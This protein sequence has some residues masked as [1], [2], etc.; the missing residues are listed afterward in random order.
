[1]QQRLEEYLSQVEHELRTVPAPQRDEELRE[2]RQHL[3]D[4]VT[5]N[6]EILGYDEEQAVATALEEFGAPKKLAREILAAWCRGDEKTNRRKVLAATFCSTASMSV[7]VAIV[8]SLGH[9][10][11]APPI[12]WEHS[13]LMQGNV[14]VWAA[15]TWAI[16][17]AITA[18][19]FA[20]HPKIG[21]WIAL[22]AISVW[23]YLATISNIEQPL[24]EFPAIAAYVMASASW[25]GWWVKI[26]TRWQRNRER[27]R[28]V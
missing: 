2:M 14:L 27:A 12:P 13:A 19:I 16:T 17:G 18:A 22:S 21:P 11:N 20:R 25:T 5:V 9:I 23:L 3:V 10:A 24:R 4:N 1:M 8:N 15:M 28:I 26:A 7:G 6:Q